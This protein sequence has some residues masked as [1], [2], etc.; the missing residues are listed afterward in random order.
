ME[1]WITT[2]PDI[3]IQMT[4]MVRQL[5]P[6][7]TGVPLEIYCFSAKQAWVD[8]ERVQADLFDHLFAILPLFNLKV[9][10]Y[11]GKV[12]YNEPT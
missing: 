7:P 8:Y 12:E 10:Q 2:N 5:Q 11:S 9:F 6:G 4:H 3:N 1:S